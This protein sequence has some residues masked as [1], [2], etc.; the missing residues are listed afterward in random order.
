MYQMPTAKKRIN[1][2]VNDELKAALEA[3]AKR[4]DVPVATKANELLEE[5][6]EM[7][8]DEL[9]DEMIE[10]RLSKTKKYL[11]HEETWS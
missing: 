1:I 2:S 11:S 5:I 3:L 4:D 10:D 9:W 6:I 8:E 7:Y